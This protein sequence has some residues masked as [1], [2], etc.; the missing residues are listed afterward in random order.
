MPACYVFESIDLGSSNFMMCGARVGSAN[1][2]FITPS[3]HHMTLELVLMKKIEIP[4][5][6]KHR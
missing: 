6:Q 5:E 2:S 1:Y 3:E 4:F